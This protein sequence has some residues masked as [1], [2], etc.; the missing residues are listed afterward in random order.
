MSLATNVVNLATRTATEAKSLRTLINGNQS[1]LSGLKTVE[2]S[3]LVDAINEL[4]ALLDGAGVKISDTT[5]STSTVWSSSK[6]N[7]KIND[8]VSALVASSPEALD[9]LKELADALGNDSSFA[10]TI[11]DAI[12]AKAPTASPTFTGNVTV[13]DG[14]FSLSKIEGLQ[15]E[16]NRRVTLFDDPNT[17]AIFFWDD[18]ASKVAPLTLSGMTINGTVLSNTAASETVAGVVERATLAEVTTGTDNTRYVSPQALR[19]EI[20]TRAATNHGH[21]SSQI[22]DFATAVP[23]AVPA[24]SETVA[25]KVELATLE[26]TLAGADSQKA[27]TPVG[28]KTVADGK[29]PKTHGHALTDANITG[30]LPI[31]Q[32]PTG[33]SG[34]TVALGNHTHSSSGITDFASAVD[35][36]INSQ[37]PAASLTVAGRIELATDGEVALGGDLVRAVT[38]AGLR[39]VMGDPETNFVSIFEA[40][41]V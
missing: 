37:V 36:R 25:G 11:T 9:T 27:V 29:A 13:P 4:L 33:N 39:S 28:L 19:Q 23:S 14:S 34:T 18:S 35:T 32:V 3:N 26:E 7:T 21:T 1:S 16:L 20:N 17:D 15:A 5:T 22:S 2:K 24:A 12:A 30:V 31:A 8:A 6:T 41:L 40:A 38:P 10:K